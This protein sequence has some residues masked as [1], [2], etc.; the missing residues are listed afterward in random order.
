MGVN[1]WLLIF[2]VTQIPYQNNILVNTI[3]SRSTLQKKCH[4]FWFHCLPLGGSTNFRSQKMDM[5]T[6]DTLACFSDS[7]MSNNFVNNKA[8]EK[9]QKGL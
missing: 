6:V 9:N 5:K 1:T 4:I 3:T 7:K 8:I 2:D